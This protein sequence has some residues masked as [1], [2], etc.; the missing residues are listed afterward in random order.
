MC[1][2]SMCRKIKDLKFPECPKCLNGGVNILNLVH[3]KKDKIIL[4]Y[5]IN[6]N[7]LFK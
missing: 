5:E 2:D 6:I 7:K 3:S 4:I 1:I